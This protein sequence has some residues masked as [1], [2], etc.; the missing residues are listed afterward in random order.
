M[1]QLAHTAAET[2]QREHPGAR[3]EIRDLPPAIGDRTTV[4]QIWANLL[5]NAFKF[6]ARTPDA[7]VLV[8]FERGAEG[9]VVYVVKD[10]GA[11]FDPQ[12]AQRIFGIFQ[13]MHHVS[14]FK[15]TGI[16]LALVKRIIERHHGRVSA[17]S[18]LGNGTTVRFSL[19]AAAAESAV[20]ALSGPE[21]L[22]GSGGVA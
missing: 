15:G 8:D 20:P 21:G 9:E 5:D 3:L 18:T 13:R 11:G 16:G 2:A 1:R 14:E 4:T 12:F 22:A 10:N 17:E 7:C 19:N 6:S